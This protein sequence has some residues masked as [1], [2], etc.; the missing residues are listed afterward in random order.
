MPAATADVPANV[1]F[2]ALDMVDGGWM[3]DGGRWIGD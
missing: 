1:S 2:A 3:E